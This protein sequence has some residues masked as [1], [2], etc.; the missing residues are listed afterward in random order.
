MYIAL[1]VVNLYGNNRYVTFTI[2]FNN[3]NITSFDSSISIG[4][5]LHWQRIGAGEA[6]HEN[7]LDTDNFLVTVGDG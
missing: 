3:F 6:A 4:G 5:T 7:V 1:A 2:C